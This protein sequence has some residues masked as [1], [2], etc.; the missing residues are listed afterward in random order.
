[1][2]SPPRLPFIP[3]SEWEPPVQCI[4]PDIKKITSDMKQLTQNCPIINSPANITPRERIAIKTIASNP[5]IVVKPAD[6]G[7]AIVIMSRE[8]YT[9]EASR[10][11]NNPHHYR[12]IPEPIYPTT[13]TK[14]LSLVQALRDGNYITKK[15][16]EF[17]QPP[18]QPRAR[19]LYLLP[20]IHKPMDQWPN[21]GLMPP[22]RPI[23]SDCS[24]ESYAISQYIDSFLK[25]IATKHPSYIKDTF[26]FTNKVSKIKLPPQAILLTLDVAAMYTNINNVDGL[27]AIQQAFQENPSPDRPD[28]ILLQ[29]IEI[30]LT[31]NDFK[32]EDKFYLQV[33][34]TAMGKIFAPQYANI[35]MAHWEAR[36]MQNT[37]IKP[38][39]H[40]RFLDDIFN[41]WLHTM[42]QL[43]DY[44]DLLNSLHQS[45][46]LTATISE[47]T[48]DFLDTTVWKGPIFATQGT[49]DIK[50]YF[51]S[52][53]THQLLR[54]SSPNSPF[55]DS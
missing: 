52:T 13:T 32:F 25:P 30:C 31:L 34:G 26:D 1:M 28:D 38:L 55:M 33:C 6:K 29:L 35:F 12:P 48:V 45:V 10:Q 18:S 24:S 43:H 37:T 39:F 8:Q 14:V 49:L 23:V 17:L 20:K 27:K 11:L 54:T 53:D 47:T 9:K 51:K 44:I 40:C 16:F 7:S 50:V 2:K 21:P 36:A 3:K 41:I 42:T 22:G 46:R 19:T 5:S 4:H 15:Q